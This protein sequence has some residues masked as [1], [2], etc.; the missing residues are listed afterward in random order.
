MLP[1]SLPARRLIQLASV[2]MKTH[3]QEVLMALP[4]I[5]RANPDAFEDQVMPD[6]AV[7]LVATIPPEK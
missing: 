3:L 6:H 7:R 5:A 2:A 4:H 1:G